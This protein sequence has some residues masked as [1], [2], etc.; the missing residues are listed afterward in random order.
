MKAFRALKRQEAGQ[1]RLLSKEAIL[2][3]HKYLDGII[4]LRGLVEGVDY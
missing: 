3:R 1:R 2:F 4:K